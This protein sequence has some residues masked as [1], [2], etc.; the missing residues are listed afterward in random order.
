MTAAADAKA[1]LLPV[2]AVTAPDMRSNLPL[3]AFDRFPISSPSLAVARS[4][5]QRTSH[6]EDGS[7][8]TVN[9]A[10]SV[11]EPNALA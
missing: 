7:V 4:A 9:Q 11:A 10:R 1:V 2:Q 8:T 6:I 5:R 3:T